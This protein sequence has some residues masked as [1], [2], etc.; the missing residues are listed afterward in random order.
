MVKWEYK[1]EIVKFDSHTVEGI[2]NRYGE[3]GWEL[4]NMIDRLGGYKLFIFKR[5]KEEPISSRVR[6]RT[7]L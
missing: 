2:L 3:E 4:V 6:T 7:K 1:V 5:R